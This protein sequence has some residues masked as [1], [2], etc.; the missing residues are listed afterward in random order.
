MVDFEK[1]YI[2]GISAESTEES[3]KSAL[4]YFGPVMK[5]NLVPEHKFGVVVFEHPKGAQKAISRHW[6][7]VDGKQVELLP[8]KPQKKISNASG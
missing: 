2:G 7:I 3:M 8:Y 4:S 1:V 6:Y 5:V